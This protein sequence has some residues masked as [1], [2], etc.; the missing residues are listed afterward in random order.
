MNKRLADQHDD[1]GQHRHPRAGSTVNQRNCCDE[2]RR[3]PGAERPRAARPGRPA[4]IRPAA[5]RRRRLGKQRR[6]GSQGATISRGM[7]AI[8]VTSAI[9]GA[10]DDRRCLAG[11][12]RGRRR[13]RR[14][15]RRGTAHAARPSHIEMTPAGAR[16]QVVAPV[17]ERAQSRQPQRQRPEPAGWRTR[18]A[19]APPRRRACTR[20]G[21]L[22]DDDHRARQQLGG[23]A[24]TSGPPSAPF[25][26]WVRPGRRSTGT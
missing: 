12:G 4:A 26:A 1:H 15:R 9:G 11:R 23:H 22:V 18:A 2:R 19:P 20:P 14:D 16:E 24:A 13:R 7:A 21:R 10:I 6:R 8:A 17:G 3:A 5:I 25:Q